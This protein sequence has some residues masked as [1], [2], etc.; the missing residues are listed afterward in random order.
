MK[1]KRISPG[2][3]IALGFLSVILIG[4]VLLTL[5]VAHSGNVTVTPLDALFSA[6]S[7]AA[8]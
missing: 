2:R 4:T 8:G 6:V 7:R 5:P 3:I 1:Q